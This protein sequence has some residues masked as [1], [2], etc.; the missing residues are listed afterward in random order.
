MT[1]APAV[2]APQTG[3]LL[4]RRFGRISVWSN[5]LSPMRA[6][7]ARAFVREVEAVGFPALWI[8]EGVAFKEIF[9]HAAILLAATDRLIVATGIA[10]I[11]ARD[12]VA[13]ANGARTLGDAYPARFVLGMGNSH[14]PMASVRGHRYARPLTRMAAYLDAMAAAPFVGPEPD[15]PTPLLLA[16]LGP[17]MLELARERAAGAHP[18]FVPVEHT[19]LARATLGPAP[20]LAVE[21]AVL[22][23]TDPSIAR[24]VAREHMA[25][26]L[27]LPNYT[28][29]LRRLGWGDADLSGGGSDRLVDALV[30]WGDMARV[31]ERIDDHL[32]RG[33]D[34]VCVQVLD[35]DPRG[36]RIE[37]IRALA[38]ELL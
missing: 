30:A 24:A 27:E 4:A 20:F 14:A 16:A 3:R 25:H 17:K 18:F 12:A 7:E 10:N 28:N 38:A 15:E 26:F 2:A 37:R 33:A 32:A 23:E 11:W 19:S 31:R 6:T 22:F 9:S 1:T 21:Q 36:S 5:R 29:N 8:A 35:R 13:M 34:N